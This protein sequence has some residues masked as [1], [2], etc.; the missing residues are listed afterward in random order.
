MRPGVIRPPQDVTALVGSDVN[1]ECGVTGDPAPVVTWRRVDG[2]P[3]PSNGRTRPV[4]HNK[5]GLLS[6]LRIERISASD[7]G[8]YLCNVENSLGSSSAWAQLTV[9]VPPTW[10]FGA[11]TSSSNQPSN[12]P[13]PKEA[14]AHAGHT[15]SLDCPADGSPK[16]LI[17]WN[18]EGRTEP[19]F[20][21]AV[22]DGDSQSRWSVL[23]NGT[24]VIRDVRREDAS[25]LWC[26]AVNEAG[27]LMARTRLEVTSISTPPPVVIEVGPA[28]QTLP[29]KSPASLPCQAEGQPVKWTKDGRPINASF[30]IET[31]IIGSS[32]GPSRSRISLSESGI[33]MIEDLQLSDAGTYTCEVGEEDQF[34]AWT[35][36]LAVASPTNPNVVFHRSPS[37]PMALP[38][39]PSQPR[40]LHKSS[41][42]LTVGWQSGSRMGASPLLGYTLEVFSSAEDD[43]VQP[44]LGS[45]TWTGPFVQVKRSWRIITRGLKADQFTLNDLQPATSYTFLVRAE[46]NHGLS[47]P[48]P[49]SPWFTT[50]PTMRHSGQVQ[51][52]SAAEL[53]DVRQ[54]LSVPRLRLDQARSLN[55]TSVRLSWQLLD[56]DSDPTLDAI[57]IWYRRSETNQNSDEDDDTPNEEVVIPMNRITS[58]NNQGSFSHTLG[59]LS[60]Y[61]RYIFFLVPSFRNVLGQPSNSKMERTME[62]GKH[63]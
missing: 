10:D 44:R 22:I 49:V 30:I 27:S 40:L 37:D 13:L 61:T 32:Q 38:G 17:F 19:F 8:R 5:S 43:Q 15:I 14:R 9:L 25:A 41:T 52:Q 36:S 31:S 4:D 51:W 58:V 50:L 20:A 57:R 48:S 24:L 53:E 59:S 63:D 26:A 6:I 55:S 47:L 35:A 62:T 45:W 21:N 1:F 23:N 54:R 39:S 7:S 46:N 33:L 28:N 34:A 3:M 16:P 42:S 56:G 18:R 60:P 12:S 2:S 29:V 11:T